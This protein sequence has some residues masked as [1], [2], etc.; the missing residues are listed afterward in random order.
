MLPIA[1]SRAPSYE[2]SLAFKRDGKLVKTLPLSEL[3]QLPGAGV[4][5]SSDPYYG[6]HKH[7]RAFPI[8]AALEAGYGDTPTKLREGTYV[9][10]ALDGYRVPIEA[11]RL[12]DGAA[13]VAVDD[14]D[15]P[16]FAPIG[17][18]KSSPL[19]AYLIWKGDKPNLETHPRP[20]QL[21]SIERV[22]AA[23]LYPHTRPRQLDEGTP[24]ARGFHLFRERCIHC[25]AINREGGSVGPELN[26]PQSIVAYRP[27]PQIRAYIQ[28]PL[29]FRYGAMPA[30]PDLSEADLD[31][32]I[33]Y[34]HAMASEP[35]DP[36]KAP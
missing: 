22:S 13:Y 25:H 8:V 3:A 6:A 20:W 15:V 19:P 12:L 11:A 9:L 32:L 29:T 23:T 2:G 33:A 30:N 35:F 18:R 34:F 36:A 4:I 16:G 1:C 5:E 14:V 27:E 7:F 28:N 21:A 10:V 31:G 26:V 17:P 24:V